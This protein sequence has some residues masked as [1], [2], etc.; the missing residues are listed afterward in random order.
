MG[1]MGLMGGSLSWSPGVN[2]SEG[3]PG[4]VKGGGACSG[5]RG[6]CQVGSPAGQDIR[7]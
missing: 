1:A 3:R 2:C 5:E 6:A 4:T 7:T